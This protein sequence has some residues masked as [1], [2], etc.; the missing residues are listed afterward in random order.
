MCLYSILVVIESLLRYIRGDPP[1][2]LDHRSI[3]DIY[4]DPLRPYSR[5]L[6]NMLKAFPCSNSFSVKDM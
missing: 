3:I 4:P 2:T 6:N 1:N 5:V